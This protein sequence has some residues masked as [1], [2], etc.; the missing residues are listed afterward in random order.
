M[1][2]ELSV[3]TMEKEASADEKLFTHSF[4]DSPSNAQLETH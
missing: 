4:W 3:L 1:P 2:E